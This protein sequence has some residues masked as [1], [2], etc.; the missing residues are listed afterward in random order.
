[1]SD[2]FQIEEQYQLKTYKKFPIAIKKGEDVWVYTS[3]GKKYLDLYGGHAVV[4]TGHCH[5][6]V[7]AAIKEQASN[8]L[9][10]SNFVYNES[11]AT[12]AKKLVDISPDG[13]S[14]AFFINT[15]AESNENAIKLARKFSGKP[16]I[17]SFEG[18]FHGRTIGALSATGITKYREAFS[19]RISDHHF[20]TFDDL[21]SVEAI[22]EKEDIG[23][24]LVETIQ[25]MAGAKTASPEFFQGLR[26]LC[27]KHNAVLI[28]DEVQTGFGRTGEF[29]FA[30][31]YGV[32]PDLITLAKGIASGVPMAALMV[33]DRYTEQVGYGDLGT[34]FGGSP[35]AS[36]ALSATIDTIIEE[37]LLEN[38]KTESA[39]LRE[40]LSGLSHVEEILGEGFL[41]GIRFQQ[42]SSVYHKKLMENHIITGGSGDPNIMRLLPPLTLKRPEIDHF[43]EVLS[44]IIKELS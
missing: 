37:K 25:R 44:K 31:R 23:G 41:V 10:Y 32:T 36:A 20:A 3:E 24:I 9:F 18:S 19:P 5:P 34:T 7:V 8:L 1:M 15:G 28:Y 17:I 6:K 29:F 35:L 39:Y 22:M 26:A 38:V 42:A 4:S 30:P 12:A 27:D 40:Q 2:I 43:L 21:A 11:R 13:F 16:G 33:H 14:Q